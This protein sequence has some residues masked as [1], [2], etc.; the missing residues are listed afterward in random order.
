MIKEYH[1]RDLV[2]KEWD[3]I[4]T[5]LNIGKELAKS[6]WKSLRDNFRKELKKIQNT[7][8]GDAAPAKR[9]KWIHFSS[10]EF[11]REF[12]KPRF[13][14]SNLLVDLGPSTSDPETTVDNEVTNYIEEPTI[15]NLQNDE[16]DRCIVDI[17]DKLTL[18]SGS[19]PSI[20]NKKQK[21]KTDKLDLQKEILEIEKLKIEWLRK[22]ETEDDDDLNFFKSLLPYMKL[23]PPIKKLTVRSK[24][25]NFVLDQLKD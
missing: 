1:N 16:T 2:D 12:I 6:K 15:W 14:S 13:T 4:A 9:T 25:Q 8:S 17:N 10:L 3:N 22:A 5:R 20:P 21:R 23:L 18:S 24:I 11:L 7:R 19:C